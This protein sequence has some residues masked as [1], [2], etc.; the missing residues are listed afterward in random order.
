MLPDLLEPVFA[1]NL[2]YRAPGTYDF[3]YIDKDKYTGEITWVDVPDLEDF[4]KF[5]AGGYAIGQ[6]ATVVQEFNLFTDTGTSLTFL[7][8]ELVEGYYAQEEG[9]IYNSEQGGWE[10]PCSSKLPDLSILVAGV[11]QTM[12][13]KYAS[14][15][16]FDPNSPMCFGGIQGSGGEFF[17]LG[18]T[19]LKSKY[20]IHELKDGKA[21]LGFAQQVGVQA[22][23]DECD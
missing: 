6:N 19:F 22:V 10:F 3:G 20:L 12:P 4:W 1:A 9:A 21:R 13:G 18:D 17:V 7:D 5:V 2:K 15:G 11:K 8:T 16:Q 23:I 14:F